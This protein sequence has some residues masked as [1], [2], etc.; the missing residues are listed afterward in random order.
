MSDSVWPH[1]R[2]PTS[3]RR[4]WDSPGKNTGVGCHFSYCIH[5]NVYSPHF[6]KTHP[7]PINDLPSLNSIKWSLVNRR[8]PWKH[9][10]DHVSSDW[11]LPSPVLRLPALMKYLH[12]DVLGFLP[13]VYTCPFIPPHNKVPSVQHSSRPVLSCICHGPSTFAHTTPLL[14]ALPFLSQQGYLMA[15][16]AVAFIATSGLYG[17]LGYWGNLFSWLVCTLHEAMRNMFL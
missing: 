11:L 16:S 4:S 14:N 9:R 5:S 12:I 8:I 6:T 17:F 15:H 3:F 7:K 2:Q 10:Y 13:L 1:R